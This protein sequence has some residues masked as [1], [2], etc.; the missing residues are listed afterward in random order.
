MPGKKL[1]AQMRGQC[2]V[3]SELQAQ[4]KPRSLAPPGAEA[5]EQVAH[6]RG[7]PFEPSWDAPSLAALAPRTPALSSQPAERA[8]DWLDWASPTSCSRPSGWRASTPTT[9][10]RDASEP[11]PAPA[12]VTRQSLPPSSSSQSSYDGAMPAQMQLRCGTGQT[13][14]GSASW[15]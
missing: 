5:P 2:D 14:L 3:P 8:T 4:L 7:Q 15:I 11:A 12:R 1:L 9:G 6:S 13:E 10:P